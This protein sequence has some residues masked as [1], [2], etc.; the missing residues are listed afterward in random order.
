[1]TKRPA[2]EH[3]A[4]PPGASPWR[5]VTIDAPPGAHPR[6]TAGP[7][8]PGGHELLRQ[9]IDWIESASWTSFKKRARVAGIH[10]AMLTHY[11]PTR[12]H[13][14]AATAG[15][16]R[17]QQG[18][19]SSHWST[20]AQRLSVSPQLAALPEGR[21]ASVQ[22]LITSALPVMQVQK[23]ERQDQLRSVVELLVITELAWHE[24]AHTLM[25]LQLGHA[26]HI[27]WRGPAWAIEGSHIEVS[28]HAPPAHLAMIGLAPTNVEVGLG[29]ARRTQ[30]SPEDMEIV[31][32]GVP[33]ITTQLEAQQAWRIGALRVQ[34]AWAQANQGAIDQV[35]ALVLSNMDQTLSL[36]PERCPPGWM[37]GCSSLREAVARSVRSGW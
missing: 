2:H 10:G 5:P 27:E 30:P 14:Q 18:W 26:A 1:M 37:Q 19:T 9:L 35:A 13:A 12:L 16:R 11:D 32:R 22:R 24:A 15:Q 3:S 31:Q 7:S 6:P 21:S 8:H 20:L 33:A 34:L 23:I 36:T 17:N 4:A 28:R 29:S 25:A